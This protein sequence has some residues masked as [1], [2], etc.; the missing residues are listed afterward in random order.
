M[1]ESFVFWV[2]LCVEIFVASLKV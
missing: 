2:Y 1:L